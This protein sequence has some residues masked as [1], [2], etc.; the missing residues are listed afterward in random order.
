MQYHDYHLRGY[1]V[2][3]FGTKL[4]LHLTWNYPAEN[5]AD[6][7]IDFMQVACYHFSHTH[8]TVLT[9]IDEKPL[10]TILK[11]EEKFLTNAAQ[12]DGVRFWE[13]DFSTYLDRLKGEGY[14][15]WRIESAIG[16]TGFVVA[17]SAQQKE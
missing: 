8:G 13:T 4:T 9:D 11:E 14:K 17:K 12:Q 3:E 2:S 7:F 1:T 6:S 5:R 10:E 16:F 15:A